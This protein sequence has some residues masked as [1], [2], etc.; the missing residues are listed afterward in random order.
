MDVNFVSDQPEKE[1]A[2]SSESAPAAAVTIS[3]I[4]EEIR[5]GAVETETGAVRVRKV[6]TN[7]MRSI[8]LGLR[9]KTV[10]VTR[11]SVNR[12][13]E[14]EYGPRQEGDTLIVPVFEYVPVFTM[15]L[16]LKEE[17]HI[18]THTL[19]KEEVR[20]VPVKVETIVVERRDGPNGAWVEDDSPNP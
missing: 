9:S 3:A 4:Q 11:V 5:V 14:S 19:E 13:V 8:P 16:T 15:Q 1:R 17:V 10:G 18:T 6:V 7:E 12:P 20:E 2:L